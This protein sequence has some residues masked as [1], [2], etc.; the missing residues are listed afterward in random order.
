MKLLNPCNWKT[1]SAWNIANYKMK[2]KHKTNNKNNDKIQQSKNFQVQVQKFTLQSV[3][4]LNFKVQA[5]QSEKCV[6]CTKVENWKL[7]FSS[8]NRKIC[9]AQIQNAKPK[10]Q[11]LRPPLPKNTENLKST[12]LRLKTQ[13]CL[14]QKCIN[15]KL[16]INK[17]KTQ[18][19]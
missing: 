2:T 15:H 19:C 7:W 1:T 18:D 9:D 10:V 3:N 16:E 12:S 8:S 6:K 11:N 14:S 17:L 5:M 13:N 4:T